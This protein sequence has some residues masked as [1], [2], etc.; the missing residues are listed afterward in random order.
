M[1]IPPYLPLLP[2]Y[3]PVMVCV[4]PTGSSVPPTGS[5]G[6]SPGS[7]VPSTVS[8]VPPTGFGHPSICTIHWSYCTLSCFR[9]DPRTGSICLPLLR[10]HQ[11]P[12]LPSARLL[13]PL[14]EVES[15]IAVRITIAIQKRFHKPMHHATSRVA[16]RPA[17]WQHVLPVCTWQY[18]LPLCV[19]QCKL[20][21]A[22]G[23]PS[24]HLHL[25]MHASTLH[26]AKPR[27]SF[28]MACLLP[29]PIPPASIHV[30]VRTSSQCPARGGTSVEVPASVHVAAPP[31]RWHSWHSGGTSHPYCL[32]PLLRCPNVKPRAPLLDS[33][34]RWL[35]LHPISSR[36]STL[37]ASVRP[38]LPA[39]DTQMQSHRRDKA[40]RMCFRQPV[41]PARM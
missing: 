13:T 35:T 40:A 18:V 28:Y 27:A 38:D 10:G 31:A 11:E 5:R 1:I 16:V 14:A 9:S 24:C 25:A 3:L 2:P 26:V 32:F 17:T 29:I 34:V 39:L 22:R 41:M 37:A 15:V 7:N 33:G 30:A 12:A 36:Q 20:P 4:L 21:L 6:P 19:R 8:T 23:N